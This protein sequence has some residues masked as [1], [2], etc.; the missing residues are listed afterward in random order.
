MPALFPSRR[1]WR[2][3]PLSIIL[4]LLVQSPW[5]PFS[6][7]LH[8]WDGS[9]AVI[10]MVTP[11]SEAST[12]FLEHSS[13]CSQRCVIGHT[14]S[15]LWCSTGASSLC[16]DQHNWTVFCI[17]VVT[18]SVITYHGWLL[19]YYLALVLGER[20]QRHTFWDV[21]S[22]FSVISLLKNSII[23]PISRLC[24]YTYEQN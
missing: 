17:S 22:L 11:I 24:S 14:C 8:V 5:S 6:D 15:V 18:L 9:K 13:R 19:V 7:L 21:F 2:P 23:K 20:M 4:P 12:I 3:P 16:V 10:P 1:R